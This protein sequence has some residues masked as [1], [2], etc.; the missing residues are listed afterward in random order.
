[1]SGRVEEHGRPPFSEASP[2]QGRLSTGSPA[3]AARTLDCLIVSTAA[4][5]GG[6]ELVVTRLARAL[7]DDVAVRAVFPVGASVE[8]M[9]TEVPGAPLSISGAVGDVSTRRGLGAV[10]GLRSFIRGLRPRV[11]NVHYGV[12]HLSL[13]DALAIWL[14]G[15]AV[16]IASVHHPEEGAPSWRNRAMTRAAATLY[17]KV[18]VNSTATARGLRAKGVPASKLALIPCGVEAASGPDRQRARD[19][20]GIP[21]DA[22]VVLTVARLVAHKGVDRVIAAAADAGPCVL[23]I[24]GTG[25]EEAAL[26]AQAARVPPGVTVRFDGFVTDLAPYYAAADVFA[27]ASSAEGFGLVFA[28]AAHHAVPSVAY[29]TGGVPDVIVHGET[30][31]LASSGDEREFAEHLKALLAD[32]H[33][34]RQLGLAA[35]T[36]ALR[37]FTTDAMVAQYERVFGLPTAVGSSRQQSEVCTTSADRSDATSRPTSGRLNAAITPATIPDG[38]PGAA[39]AGRYAEGVPAGGV[40]GDQAND[41]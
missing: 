29:R 17:H 8:R 10:L 20:L 9:L 13:K 5:F 30:G 26:R 7:A 22:R 32:P 25:P 12:N 35:Q 36:R 24:V 41:S 34:R 21:Q 37:L 31:L 16:R 39:S 4:S 19:E 14:S 18:V 1:M 28:E 33:R 2:G 38:H 3:H 27:L 11:V 6:T 15:A 23:V 40:R